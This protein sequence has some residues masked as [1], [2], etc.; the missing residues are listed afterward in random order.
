MASSSDA[1]GAP[2]FPADPLAGDAPRSMALGGAGGGQRLH[3]E[4]AGKVGRRGIR[5]RPRL[6]PWGHRSRTRRREL[7]RW[8][9]A[10]NGEA[11]LGER[12]QCEASMAQLQEQEEVVEVAHSSMA[13]AR[14]RGRARRRRRSMGHGALLGRKELGTVR[15]IETVEINKL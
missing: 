8:D 11:A 1:V 4:G 14:R 13:R 10:R 12:R 2:F 6:E 9:A 7:R 5:R 15:S 3:R